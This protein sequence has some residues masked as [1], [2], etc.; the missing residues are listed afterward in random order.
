MRDHGLFV[1]FAPR[2]HPTIAGVVV[3]EHGEHGSNAAEVAHHILQTYF[4]KL[5]GRALP[6]PPEV[7]DMDIQ[8]TPP[9]GVPASDEPD[10]GGDANPQPV[11]N[12]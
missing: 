5:D 1:F 6:E 2:D 11:A 8:L 4:A 12:N 3:A 7:N 10:T 9:P